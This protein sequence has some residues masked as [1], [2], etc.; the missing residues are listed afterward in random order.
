MKF[1]LVQDLLALTMVGIIE[2]FSLK[3]ASQAVIG[4]ASLVME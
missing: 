2:K 4:S 1:K 3:A